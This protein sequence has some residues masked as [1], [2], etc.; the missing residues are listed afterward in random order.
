MT[1]ASLGSAFRKAVRDSPVERRITPHSLRHSYATHLLEDGVDLRTIQV[2]LGHRHVSSTAI[3]THVST[4]KL[5]EAAS[6]LDS[7]ANLDE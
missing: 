5:H 1:E 3:Y 7:L 6:P 2:V 4:Q